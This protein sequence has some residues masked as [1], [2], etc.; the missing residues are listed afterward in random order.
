MRFTPNQR[1][2]L[3]AFA[4]TLLS[5]GTIFGGSPAQAAPASPPPAGV[6]ASTLPAPLPRAATDQ[7]IFNQD[8]IIESGTQVTENIAVFRGNV[9]IEEGGHLRG[10]LSVLGGDVTILGELT[11]NLAVVGGGVDLRSTARV[12]GDI[13]AIGGR[14]ERAPGA[15]VQGNIV[16]GPS[17]GNFSAPNLEG[18]RNGLSGMEVRSS[19]PSAFLSF[20]WRLVRAFL[21]TL[22]FTGLATLIYWL[23][24]KPVDK[25]SATLDQNLALSFAVGLVA[26]VGVLGLSFIFGITIILI[27]LSVLLIAGLGAVGLT[28]FTASAVWLAGRI[29]HA[30]PEQARLGLHPILPVTASAFVLSGLVFLDWA[31]SACLG[32]VVGLIVFSPGVGA[33]LVNQSRSRRIHNRAAPSDPPPPPPAPPSPP[34][35]LPGPL[36]S[37]PEKS[38]PAVD[39]APGAGPVA[40][41]KPDPAGE[42]ADFTRLRGIGPTYAQ[43]LHQAGILTFA[44]LA[45]LTPE[46]IGAIIG[47]SAERVIQDQLREQAAELS[48]T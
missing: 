45:D 48:G 1:W 20:V 22:L 41:A 2:A 23:F 39:P 34:A 38:E 19:Q 13:S 6:A 40:E 11:G 32:V 17:S 46:A 36:P 26:L 12:S 29:Q 4:I 31:I 37:S 30:W 8:L 9:V 3:L 10:D 21:L 16:S 28:G 44:Q 5:L 35:L 27:C 24:P 25:I 43:R 18:S 14:I 7:Q 42:P 15:F 47:W 33:I